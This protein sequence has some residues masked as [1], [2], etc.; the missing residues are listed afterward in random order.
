MPVTGTGKATISPSETN[1]GDTGTYTV[2]YTANAGLYGG[3]VQLTIPADW[4]VEGL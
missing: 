3:A 4:A 2:T 1:A